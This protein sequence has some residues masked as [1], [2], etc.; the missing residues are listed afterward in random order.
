MAQNELYI[1]ELN[2]PLYKK[3]SSSMVPWY[4]SKRKRKLLATKKELRKLIE[5]THKT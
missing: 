2:I 1:H 5:R 4:E 3:T